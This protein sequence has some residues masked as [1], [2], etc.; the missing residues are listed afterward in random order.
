LSWPGSTSRARL[1]S[2]KESPCNFSS[3][4]TDSRCVLSGSRPQLLDPS[5]GT[6]QE[7]IDLKAVG[8]GAD[9]RRDPAREPHQRR[10]QRPI[11]PE[12]SLEARKGDLYALPLAVLVGP[13]GHQRDPALGHK[14]CPNASLR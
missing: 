9:L 7:A 6:P 10:R 5:L 11:Q 3:Q 14:A 8:V 4:G 2:V 12:R 13:L 1:F